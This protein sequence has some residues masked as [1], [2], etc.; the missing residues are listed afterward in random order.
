[1]HQRVLKEESKAY[2]NFSGRNYDRCL[3]LLLDSRQP[4]VQRMIQP[5]IDAKDHLGNT[6]LHVASFRSNDGAVRR[7]DITVD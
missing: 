4:A 6:P 2:H 3:A 1:M 7:L 5:A